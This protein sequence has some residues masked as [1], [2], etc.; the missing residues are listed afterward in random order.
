MGADGALYCGR[1][2][3]R[4]LRRADPAHCTGCAREI[5]TAEAR[6]SW[7]EF[8]RYLCEDCAERAGWT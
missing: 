5:G 7:A 3:R 2:G 8:G 6:R 4:Y 1:C